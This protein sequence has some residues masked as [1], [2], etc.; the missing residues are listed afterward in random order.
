MTDSQQLLADYANTGS[1]TAFGQLVTMYLDLVYSTAFRLVDGDA[2]QAE[3]VAQTVFVDLC[4][5]AGKMPNSVMLGGWLHRHTCFVARKVMRGDRR[6]Q[7]RERQAVQM[8]IL[9]QSDHE[10]ANLAPLLDEAINKLKEADRKA[11]LF[12]FYERMDL[13]SVGQALG[14][15]E[16]AAQ[17]RVSRALDE[18]QVI[19]TRQGAC[20]SASALGMMLAA[21]AVTSAPAGLATTLA[22]TV[23]AGVGT[24]AG[25]I[26]LLSMTKLKVGVWSVVALASVATPWVMQYRATVEARQENQEL[27]QQLS[28]LASMAHENQRLSNSLVSTT[29]PTL[30]SKEL[31]ELLRLRGEVS[32][33][34]DAERENARMRQE[35]AN[36]GSKQEQLRLSS[37]TDQPGEPQFV[38]VSGEVAAPGRYVWTNGM[39]LE[40]IVELAQ[41]YTETADRSVVRI[42]DA[43]GAWLTFGPHGSVDV[44]GIIQPGS[45]IQILRSEPADV[46]G[47]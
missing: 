5:E 40:S 10:P 39:T 21:Q 3:D 18:L 6:R 9:N 1:E 7:N 43:S 26:N 44:K 45:M 35:I 38:F 41:G 25:L 8:S 34:R 47:R 30:P 46:V 14:T 17:K 22:G 16:D 15:S 27:R 4:R 31:S 13:R 24:S 28:Q 20:V 11:I 2:H 32:R 33:L 12:R 19:L 37:E 42:K 29:A 23:F 36:L